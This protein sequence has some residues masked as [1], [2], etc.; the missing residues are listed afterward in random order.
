MKAKII[1]LK[2]EENKT[3]ITRGWEEAGNRRGLINSYQN[4]DRKNKF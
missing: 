4:I 3:V 2:V 1:D